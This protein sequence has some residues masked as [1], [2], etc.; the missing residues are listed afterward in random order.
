MEQSNSA[1]F[2][3]WAFLALA[4]SL[5]VASAAGI[6]LAFDGSFLWFHAVESGQPFIPHHRL[7]N[8]LLQT[9]PILVSRVIHETRII[10]ALFSLAYLLVP[11]TAL[12]L[13]WGIIRHRAPG[14]MLW[15]VGWV[16]LAPLPGQMDIV[17][18]A[19]IVIQM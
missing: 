11:L 17:A 4:A 1:G 18:E 3:K 2:P 16:I 7:I 12:L 13:S 9:G 6:G 8:I 15:S 5:I 19:N 10:S 14:L